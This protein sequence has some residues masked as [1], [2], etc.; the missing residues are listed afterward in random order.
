MGMHNPNPNIYGDYSDEIDD[1][2]KM[3]IS[4]LES[5]LSNAQNTARLAQERMELYEKLLDMYFRMISVSADINI[6]SHVEEMM[7][8]Y[9]MGFGKRQYELVNVKST[10]E[11]FAENYRYLLLKRISSDV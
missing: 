7:G 11:D 5:A 9:S 2:A 1:A 10:L 3:K 8:L 6:E 4:A